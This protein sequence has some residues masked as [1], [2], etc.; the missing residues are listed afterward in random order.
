MDQT[1]LPSEYNDQFGIRHAQSR[2]PGQVL[3]HVIAAHSLTRLILCMTSVLP[4]SLQGT[5]LGEFILSP[6]Y[7]CYLHSHFD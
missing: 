5:H 7:F 2:T 6:S 1:H 3:F 4:L